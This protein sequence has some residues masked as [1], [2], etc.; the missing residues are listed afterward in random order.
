MKNK[1]LAYIINICFI[2]FTFIAALD[3]ICFNKP[4]YNHEYK[5]NNVYETIGISYE[6]L[7]LVSDNLF[8]YLKDE[9]SDFNTE[10]MINDQKVMMF[11]QREI[12]HMVDVKDLYLKVKDVAS[13]SGYILI[14]AVVFY[15]NQNKEIFKGIKKSFK[16]VI[17][18][19]GAMVSALLIYALIDFYNFWNMFHEI[20]FNND[21]WLLNP[22]TDR[23]I[24]MV[25]Q[26]FFF[27]LIMMILVV[28]VIL[29]FIYYFIINFM[30]KREIQK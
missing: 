26:K 16:K 9:K 14:I 17:L 7:D 3:F 18:T 20:F 2:I 8:A 23:M 6:D 4:F 13:I 21:L 27:D 25:P 24:L 5:A 30:E 19:L 29:I 22:L 12:D 28:F 10:V 11:N 1:I 15:V